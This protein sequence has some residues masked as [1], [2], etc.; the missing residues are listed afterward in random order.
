T[1]VKGIL[2]P[3]WFWRV[4]IRTL[5]YTGMRRKQLVGMKWEDIDFDMQKVTLRADS[6]K[7]KRSWEIPLPP[8]C[9]EDLETLKQLTGNV[10]GRAVSGQ[11][12]VFNVTLFH[13]R[14]K[15]DQL[16]TMQLS[17]FF[18]RLMDESGIT[19][20]PHRFRHSFG[21][22]AAKTGEIRQVQA[23]LGHT[24]VKTTYEYVQPDIEGMRRVGSALQRI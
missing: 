21:T 7:T 20:S 14:Y 24:N 23:Q 4:V 22:Q 13:P 15:G 2:P 16:T 9:R 5:Y 19:V 6:S 8:Q 3:V 12:Q 18:R 11:E 17:G 10:R 1:E